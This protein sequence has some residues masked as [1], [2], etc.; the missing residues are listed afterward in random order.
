LAAQEDQVVISLGRGDFA[1]AADVILHS[2]DLQPLGYT[3]ALARHT[4]ATAYKSLAIATLPNLL[5]VAV[6]AFWGLNPVAAAAI[7]GSSAILA[8]LNSLR[9][10]KTNPLENGF[11]GE[12][13][14]L[15]FLRSRPH[16][17]KMLLF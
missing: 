8:E 4:L 3:F 16:Y 10:L 2:Q 15:D 13:H 12:T 6:G 5:V 1:A 7:N 14:F 11:L 9:S 17:Q